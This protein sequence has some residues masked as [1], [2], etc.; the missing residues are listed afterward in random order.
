M[1]GPCPLRRIRCTPMYI[2]P[3]QSC[4]YKHQEFHIL[5]KHQNFRL[6]SWSIPV[7]NLNVQLELGTAQYILLLIMHKVAQK[8]S[9]T[10][11]SVD[12]NY[13]KG[14]FACAT[15]FLVEFNFSILCNITYKP[16][17]H[18]QGCTKEFNYLFDCL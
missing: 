9:S 2:L 6:L 15:R 7:Q 18:K 11:S 8:I 1:P 3:L 17:R 12:G 13:C 4:N 14:I 10:F 5:T 16:L